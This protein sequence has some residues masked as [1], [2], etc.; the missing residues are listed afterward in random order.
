[1]RRVTIFKKNYKRFG[2]I[3]KYLTVGIT[4]WPLCQRKNCNFSTMTF[5]HM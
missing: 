2:A 1:M 4:S 5:I 3:G